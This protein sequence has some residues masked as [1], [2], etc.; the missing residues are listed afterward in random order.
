VRPAVLR[1][2]IGHARRRLAAKTLPG[3]RV[4]VSGGWLGRV[5]PAT[6]RGEPTADAIAGNLAD[7]VAVLPRLAGVRVARAVADRVEAITPDLVPIVDRLPGAANLLVAAGWSGAGWGPAPAYVA[8]VAEWLLERRRP[9]LL[10][11]FGLARFGG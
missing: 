10:A 7:A 2:V 5:D 11:P 9:D 4:M 8:L 6:G 3:G 1:H